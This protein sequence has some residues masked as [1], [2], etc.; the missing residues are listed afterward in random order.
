MADSA[1]AQCRSRPRSRPECGILR[2]GGGERLE[3]AKMALGLARRQGWWRSCSAGAIFPGGAGGALRGRRAGPGAVRSRPRGAT[4][5]VRKAA[6][7]AGGR[8]AELRAWVALSFPRPRRPPARRGQGL[9]PAASCSLPLKCEERSG[10]GVGP[11]SRWV[12]TLSRHHCG[13]RWGEGVPVFSP[14]A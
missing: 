4:L 2:W 1:R 7:G 6:H 3:G 5:W 13:Q 10:L 9:G 12:P 8:T 11:C 14:T